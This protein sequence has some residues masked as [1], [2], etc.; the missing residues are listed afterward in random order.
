[1]PDETRR[2]DAAAT[3]YDRAAADVLPLVYEELDRLEAARIVAENPAPMVQVNQVVH[4]AHV[5][6]GDGSDARPWPGRA[7]FW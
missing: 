4:E 7:H 3:G 5:R 6:L 1:M 2:L